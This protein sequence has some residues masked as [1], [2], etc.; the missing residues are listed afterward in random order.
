MIPVIGVPILRGP[1][2]LQELL[3]SVDVPVGRFLVIDNGNVVEEPYSSHI[4]VIKPG[5]NLGV[6]ASWN[7]IIE[8]AA[9]EWCLI[10]NYDL[11]FAP[12][13]LDRL[14]EAM[15]TD[16]PQVATLGTFSAFGINQAA[17]ARAGTFDEN[18]HPAYYEDNDF[19][20][21]C[22]LTGTPM[23]HLPSALRHRVSSTIA[24][25]EYRVQNNRTFPENQAY[26]VRK[27]GSLPRYERFVT[28]FNRGGDPRIWTLDPDRIAAQQWKLYR[29]V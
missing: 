4:E 14:T 22:E 9:P 29:E 17:V 27:W 11:T 21:R 28:P 19:H 2:L 26:Y 3:G 16:Q 13:D 1:E 10:S 23:V 7:R 5:R 25:H 6:A 12:G 20:Y 8:L 15:A 18:F 24:A